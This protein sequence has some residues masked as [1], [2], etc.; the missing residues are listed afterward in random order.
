MLALLGLLP[1]ARARAEEWRDPPRWRLRGELSTG[2]GGGRSGG[3]TLAM[4]PTSVALSARVWGPLSFDLHVEGVLAGEAYFACGGLRR[5]NAALGGVGLRADLAHG[6]SAPW[7]DPFVELRG[8]V[9]GQG[10]G[11][12]VDGACG[13][14]MVFGTGGA[15]VGLDAWLGRVA[16]TVAIGYDYLPIGQA[17]ALS[18]GAATVLF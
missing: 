4:F 2:F 3:A 10:R 11:R 12:D 7:V 5:P 8:G 14:A 17:L 18:L 1:W 6:K 9:G 16:V 15:R 13:G